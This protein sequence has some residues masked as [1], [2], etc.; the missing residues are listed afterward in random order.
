MVFSADLFRKRRSTPE[1]IALE[2]KLGRIVDLSEELAQ[3]N[4][5]VQAEFDLQIAAT[6]KAQ[7]EAEQASRLASLSEEQRKATER[8]VAAQIEGALTK[9]TKSER[10]FQVL[11]AIAAFFAGIA[12]S[13]IGSMIITWVQTQ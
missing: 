8:M 10:R 5:E 6:R 9:S 7:A 2:M 12:A 3:I 11:I 1:P 13:V 4:K